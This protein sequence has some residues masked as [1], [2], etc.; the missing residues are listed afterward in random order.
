M[1]PVPQLTAEQRREAL[2][3][4]HSS[5]V[6]RAKLKQ[7]LRDR[8]LSLLDV[9]A[10]ADADPEGVAARSRPLEIIRSLPGWRKAG[11]AEALLHECEI[12]EQRRIRGLG[13]HQRAA[14]LARVSPLLPV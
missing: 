13:P 14:L 3:R 6:E 1:T 10:L 4:A 12:A 2:R 7:A 11:R 8:K 9:F 5:R